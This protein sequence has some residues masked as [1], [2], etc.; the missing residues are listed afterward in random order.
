MT[1]KGQ[2][3]EQEQR[4]HI[5]YLLRLWRVRS[6]DGIVWRA[7]LESAR[8]GERMGF[9]SLEDLF[10]FLENETWQITEEQAAHGVGGKGGDIDG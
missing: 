4:R 6:Q 5:S 10:S 2:L 9:V 8:A 1:T 3:S 7:S